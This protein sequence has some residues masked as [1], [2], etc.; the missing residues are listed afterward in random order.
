MC[1]CFFEQ[2]HQG[3]HPL[4]LIPHQ[5]HILKEALRALTWGLS[6]S[7]FHSKDSHFRNLI[8]SFTSPFKNLNVRG[9]IWLPH[10][11]HPQNRISLFSFI[12]DTSWTLRLRQSQI[13]SP[14]DKCIRLM[15]I[16]KKTNMIFGT[17]ARIQLH[18]GT[19]EK[20]HNIQMK[21]HNKVMSTFKTRRS[22]KLMISISLTM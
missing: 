4:H 2:C 20:S 10:Q 14:Y 7:P 22:R 21:L 16:Q 3:N 6:C 11:K 8:P 5:P 12:E 9:G 18:T 15:F 13:G 17:T 1:S 19:K